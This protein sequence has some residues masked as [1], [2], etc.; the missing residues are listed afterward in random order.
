M[1][2][3]RILEVLMGLTQCLIGQ[4]NPEEV[5]MANSVSSQMRG[6]R[7]VGRANSALPPVSCVS[8]GDQ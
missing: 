7:G 8:S 2:E 5:S 1:D 4:D 6:F 3:D